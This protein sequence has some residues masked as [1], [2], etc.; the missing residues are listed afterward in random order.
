MGPTVESKDT[1]SL[2]GRSTSLSVLWLVDQEQGHFPLAFLEE[3]PFA[4][5]FW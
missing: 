2:L 5:M 4:M 3:N 1:A